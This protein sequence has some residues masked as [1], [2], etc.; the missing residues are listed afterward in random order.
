MI[1]NLNAGNYDAIMAGMSITDERKQTIDFTQNYK[2]PTPSTF[3]VPADSTA[4]FDP[5]SRACAS[6]SRARPSRPPMPSSTSP[7]TTPRQLR[8]HRPGPRR[9]QR[10]Q[11]RCVLHRAR[12]PRRGRGRLERRAEACAAGNPDRR[13]RRRRPAQGRRRA[14]D[15]VQRRDHRDEGGRH[16][17]RADRQ[18]VPRT[19]SRTLLRRVNRSSRGAAAPLVP[20]RITQGGYAARPMGTTCRLRSRLLACLLHQR[21]APA[22]VRQR[23]VHAVRGRCSA[24]RSRCSSG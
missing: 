18:V 2:P 23:A 11:S 19:G 16:A 15:Q 9:P 17:V 4:T 21:Q 24:R 20:S 14:R 8:D 5:P 7:P 10:R 6:A 1:P 3:I 12:L 13:R 22:M